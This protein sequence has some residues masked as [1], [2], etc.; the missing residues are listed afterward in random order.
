MPAFPLGIND[1]LQQ[2]LAQVIYRCLEE[3]GSTK[4][5]FYILDPATRGFDLAC[6]YGWPRNLPPPAH[7]SPLD[8]LLVMVSRERRGFAVNDARKVR[9]LQSFAVGSDHP[10]FHLAPVYDRGDW[11]GL[12]VQRDP[13]RG[14]PFNPDQQDPAIQAICEEL[15]EAMRSAGRTEDAPTWPDETPALEAITP[16][17]PEVSPIRVPAPPPAALARIEPGKSTAPGWGAPGTSGSATAASGASHPG[18]PFRDILAGDPEAFLPEQQTFFWETA[19]HL[20][21]LAP[22]AAVVLWLSDPDTVRP[23]LA[24]SRFPLS[25]DLKHQLVGQILAQVPNLRRKDVRLLLKAEWPERDPVAGH[26]T[27]VLP[28]LLE[29]EEVGEDNLLMLLRLEDRPFTAQEQEDV[30]QV[31]RMLG[32]YLQEVQLHERYHQAFLSVSH[33]ILSSAEG[34]LPAMRAHSVNTAERSRDLARRIDLPTTEVEAVSISAI[35]HDVGTLLLD[36]RVLD[37][38]RLSPEELA[39][40]RTHP[41]LASTFLKDLYFPFNVL[42]I[43]RHHHENWDGS[44]YPEGLTGEAIPIG[45]R[46]IRLVEAYEMMISSTPYRAAKHEDEALAEIRKLSGSHFDP[47]LVAAFLDL[48][49]H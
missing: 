47:G 19:S 29:E 45:S 6:H 8:P 4:A 16:P 21:R 33:R 32:F 18:D 9:E 37:K 40:V 39:Q 30:R 34:R 36:Y 5:A 43:I 46:I 20:C 3:V 10:R 38:P 28:V 13:A 44:G 17:R 48:L 27:T 26:F 23:L 15:V 1:P 2:C 24:F 49:G 35:L 7:L 22:C 12:L 14:L 42:D 11:R 41:V 31:S 25:N